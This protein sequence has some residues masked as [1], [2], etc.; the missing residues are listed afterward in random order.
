MPRSRLADFWS[1]FKIDTLSKFLPPS[2]KMLCVI[3]EREE[4]VF[5]TY[6]FGKILDGSTTRFADRTPRTDGEA[7]GSTRLIDEETVGIQGL[8]CCPCLFE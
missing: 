5:R 1:R 7:S 4:E 3:G 8:D 6:V 2:R